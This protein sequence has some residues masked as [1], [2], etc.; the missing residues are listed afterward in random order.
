MCLHIRK[1]CKMPVRIS[2]YLKAQVSK[3]SIWF[4]SGVILPKLRG[5][6]G[7]LPQAGGRLSPATAPGKAAAPVPAGATLQHGGGK[8]L[9]KGGLLMSPP[10]ICWKCLCSPGSRSCVG[11]AAWQGPGWSSEQLHSEI[12]S[13]HSTGSAWVA[14]RLVRGRSICASYG[15]VEITCLLWNFSSLTCAV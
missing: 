13:V 14:A 6:W 5:S 11:C 12:P 7:L 9:G 8:E 2:R 1:P 4:F 3:Q 15:H 10:C